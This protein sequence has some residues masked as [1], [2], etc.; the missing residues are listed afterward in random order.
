M[1]FKTHYGYTVYVYE[2]YD[3]IAVAPKFVSQRTNRSTDQRPA[4]PPDLAH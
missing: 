1:T 3:F 2:F 4:A